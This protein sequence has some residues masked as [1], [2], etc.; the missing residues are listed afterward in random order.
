MPIRPVKPVSSLKLCMQQSCVY[1]LVM[2]STS[3]S[4][5][6]SSPTKSVIQHDYKANLVRLLPKIKEPCSK[7]LKKYLQDLPSK[8]F[9]SIFCITNIEKS[10]GKSP[11]YP[12]SLKLFD[13]I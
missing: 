2:H 13:E 8:N 6:N 3:A 11:E 5:V 1:C 9:N 12:N 10:F 4:F 7:I